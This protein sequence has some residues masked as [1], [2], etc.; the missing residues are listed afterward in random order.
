[1]ELAKSENVEAYSLSTLQ[2]RPICTVT[3]VLPD[4]GHVSFYQIE[5]RQWHLN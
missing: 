5:F 2:N 4:S 1:M 3:V